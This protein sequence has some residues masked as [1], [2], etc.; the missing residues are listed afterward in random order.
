MYTKLDKL[1][2]VDELNKLIGRNV[3]LHYRCAE[4]G[5]EQVAYDFDVDCFVIEDFINDTGVRC[6][7][8]CTSCGKT[9]S[10]LTTDDIIAIETLDDDDVIGYEWPSDSVSKFLLDDEKLTT[11][12]METVI[13]ACDKFSKKYPTCKILIRKANTGDGLIVDVYNDTLLVENMEFIY[14][15]IN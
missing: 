12:G 10:T 11:D 7:L 8:D 3:V 1:P 5:D 4:C 6:A 14:S 9:T 13:D 2:L 15:N